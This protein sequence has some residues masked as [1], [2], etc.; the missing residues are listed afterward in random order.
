YY[1][2]SINRQGN[3]YIFSPD[4]YYPRYVF[5]FEGVVVQFE[6]TNNNGNSKV[7]YRYGNSGSF[8]NIGNS[9]SYTTSSSNNARFTFTTPFVV[10]VNGR[11]YKIN[12]LNRDLRND[13]NE[14]QYRDSQRNYAE[15]NLRAIIFTN[16]T[17]TLDKRQIKFKK[18]NQTYESY[19][20]SADDIRYPNNG[21]DANMYAAYVD[22]TEYVRTHGAGNYFVADIA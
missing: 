8:I 17:K 14:N 1:S 5:N 16:L 21:T 20:A 2:M 22:V 12:Y 7:R 6:F 4:D 9:G 18:E 3:G 19:T 10:T 13:R 15:V 11:E